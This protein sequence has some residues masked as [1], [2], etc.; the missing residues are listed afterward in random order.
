MGVMGAILWVVAVVIGTDGFVA[1]RI[2][3]PTA[4]EGGF[5]RA[6]WS[7]VLRYVAVCWG[8][9]GG[10]AKLVSEVL[11]HPAFGVF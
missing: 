10:G 2:L 1:F 4:G 3:A 9:W 11:C 5:G 8:E 6:V 7:P